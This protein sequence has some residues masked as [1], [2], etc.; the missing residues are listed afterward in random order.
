MRM[1]KEQLYLTV[2]VAVLALFIG[3]IS[4]EAETVFLFY[5]W[6]AGMVGIQIAKMSK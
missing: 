2:G 6:I 1:Y 3:M 4:P 5:I